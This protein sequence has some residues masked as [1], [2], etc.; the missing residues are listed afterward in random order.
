M[1]LDVAMSF[2]H[3]CDNVSCFPILS[4][5]QNTSDVR[6]DEPMEETETVAKVLSGCSEC[7]EQVLHVVQEQPHRFIFGMSV[8]LPR[9]VFTGRLR[10]TL[11]FDRRRALK[12]GLTKGAAFASM[13]PQDHGPVAL[14]FRPPVLSSCEW[15]TFAVMFNHLSIEVERQH[16]S[17]CSL[18]TPNY[19][20]DGMREPPIYLLTMES[21][22]L[23]CLLREKD[24]FSSKGCYRM[25]IDGNYLFFVNVIL[26]QC[27]DTDTDVS[28]SSMDTQLQILFE[29][30]MK[31]MKKKI[32]DTEWCHTPRFM[33]GTALDVVRRQ[34]RVAVEE[35]KSC[36]PDTKEGRRTIWQLAREIGSLCHFS[37]VRK[38][39]E[40]RRSVGANEK[41]LLKKYGLFPLASQRTSS[42]SI[43]IPSKNEGTGCSLWKFI[44]KDSDGLFHIQLDS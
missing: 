10:K 24:M 19:H 41:Y 44:F 22:D 27:S 42:R 35:L 9:S 5:D 4:A 11:S 17:I 25:V 29:K 15:D 37:V 39:M 30:I 23:F 33:F 12:I 7:F 16:K 38:I 3:T 6:S 21:V 18:C 26:D 34:R 8:I 32:H 31:I 28:G 2:G 1:D 36:F 43:C 13:Y 20:C 40:V 14:R